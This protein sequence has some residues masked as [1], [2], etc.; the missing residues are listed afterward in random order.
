MT[1]R[2]LV[3]LPLGIAAL[4]TM[5]LSACSAEAGF[6]VTGDELADN[7]AG[8]LEEQIGQRPELDCGS[9]DIILT[10]GKEVPCTLT[11]PTTGSEYDTTVTITKVDGT[12]YEIQ[13]QVADEPKGG[14]SASA[15]DDPASDDPASSDDEAGLEVAATDLA[16]AAAD[17]LEEQ[18]GQRPTIDCGELNITIYEG[19]TT[20][21]DLIDDAAG[22]IYEVTLTITTIEGTNFEFDVAVASE[23]K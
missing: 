12:E 11:D 5:A 1:S 20:Y 22:E 9:E 6:T 2:R 4:A 7:A 14:D 13:V 10:E 8:A 19:R 21:C 16:T 23:P 3:A 18:V 15:S 17:A